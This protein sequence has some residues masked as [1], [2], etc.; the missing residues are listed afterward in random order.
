[1]TEHGTTFGFKVVLKIL[2]LCS[3][4]LNAYAT[5]MF[6]LVVEI[7]PQS[8][9]YW[10]QRVICIL[11][12]ST[13]CVLNCMCV[14][15]NKVPFPCRTSCWTVQHKK[16]NHSTKTSQRGKIIFACKGPSPWL[17]AKISTFYTKIL[18]WRLSKGKH[19]YTIMANQTKRGKRNVL[20][21][22][23]G[24]VPIVSPSETRAGNHNIYN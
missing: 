16:M 2:M 7:M 17:K 11:A 8:F 9:N 20:I 19:F 21:Q 3:K 10:I 22:D 15:E 24:G 13:I 1:M 12:L 4:S 23:R 18:S 14:F 5:K 6:T